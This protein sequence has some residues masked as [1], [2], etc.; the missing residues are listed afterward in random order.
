MALPLKKLRFGNIDARYE[1]ITRDP[2]TI[3][4]FKES[5][6]EPTGL[7]IEEFVKGNRFFVHGMK[8]AG[9]TAFLRYL[10]L[11]VE[12]NHCLTSFTSFSTDV[13]DA[14]R[15]RIYK[16]N[17]IRIF[18]QK[19]IEE[20]PSAVEMWILFIFRMLANLISENRRVFTSH[21]NIHIFGEM[22]RQFH[23]GDSKSVLAFLSR[24][25]KH[26]RYKIKNKNFSAKLKGKDGETEVERSIDDIVAN[27]FVLLRD[28]SW[29][30]QNGIYL[31]FD[32][33][34]LS[35]S[36]RTQHKRDA[37][38]IRDL[39]IAIDRIN[40]FFTEQHK[41]VYLIAAA[42]SEVLKALNVPTHEINKIL[43]DR[44]RELRWFGLTAGDR[45]PIVHLLEKKIQASEKVLRQ[46][47]TPNV[48][49][50]YFQNN[51][52]GMSPQSL[53][54]ELTW[55]NPRDLVLL[56][57]QAA[58]NSEHE[59][60]FGEALLNKVI[61]KFGEDAW[62]ERA[63]ELNVEYAA[64]EIHSIKRILLNFER[65]FRIDRFER[66]AQTRSRN[67]PNIKNIVAKRPAAKIL[68]DLYRVGIIGQSSKEPKLGSSGFGALKEHW[69]YRGDENFDANA[70][71]IVH[72]GLWPELRLGRIRSN[73]E[74]VSLGSSNNVVARQSDPRIWKPKR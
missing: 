48:F 54:V 50:T 30:G 69:A 40:T 25:V 7:S 61:D 33:L 20:N 32:E 52:F 1:V 66:E 55:C 49:D 65:Y 73:V 17:G 29:E 35:F 68:E 38:L 10:K 14:E 57:G 72:R 45:W 5:F 53:V 19:E 9:K 11:T 42:R 26:G 56:F 41:P 18:E 28:L 74:A 4:H 39:I 70:W 58:E 34:N 6:L 59:P 62:N 44:G 64:I 2:T 13:S 27:G 16:A 51:I 8:G 31:F 71:M 46:K 37:V 21:N 24:V 36:S 43:T 3:E 15:N 12:E 47:I 23:E 67:D 22:T 63:E 60:R